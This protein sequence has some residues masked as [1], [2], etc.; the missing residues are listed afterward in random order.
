MHGIVP[1]QAGCLVGP[2]PAMAVQPAP[3]PSPLQQMPVAYSS[4]F[5]RPPTGKALRILCYGD[6][7][8][9]GFC[10]GGRA[11]D[12]YA[13]T[14]QERLSGTPAAGSRCE[15]FTCGLSGM[16]A[17][18]MADFID[19]QNLVDVMGFHGKGLGRILDEHGPF[20]LVAIMAGT[21][22]MSSGRM[23]AQIIESLRSLHS[24]CHDRGVSSVALAPPPAP[25]RGPVWEQLRTQV[26]DSLKQLADE[27]P[28]SLAACIDPAV[29]VDS[30]RADLWDADGLHFSPLGSSTFGQN[31]AALV[32]ED[33][34][35]QLQ[36]PPSTP[37]SDGGC[38]LENWPEQEASWAPAPAWSGAQPAPCCWQPV[39][40]MWAAAV[41]ICAFV[42]V[43]V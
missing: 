4:V 24:A 6:S 32:V 18:T 26:L 22:D 38:S 16:R 20:D 31:L 29:L 27:G 9:V 13:R 39:T 25:S 14:L 15:V 5:S 3:Q 8:T 2:M 17:D 40:P 33:V 19:S 35:P 43:Q 12:P 41:P 42:L 28:S 30:E 36:T 34:L 21:N 1:M 10:C 37:T 11:F 23:P 7:M